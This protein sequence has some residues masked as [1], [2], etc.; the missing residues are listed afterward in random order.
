MINLASSKLKSSGFEDAVS[1]MNSKM[2][3]EGI[4]LQNVYFITYLYWKYLK[5]LTTQYEIKNPL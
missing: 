4:Y 1:Q 2:H 3:T 5:T